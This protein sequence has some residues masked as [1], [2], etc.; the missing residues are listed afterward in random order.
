MDLKYA[1]LVSFLN[2]SV[3]D[4]LSLQCTFWRSAPKPQTI[5][6]VPCVSVKVPQI[7]KIWRASSGDGISLAG[8]LLDLSAITASVAYSFV[9]GYPFR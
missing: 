8:V 3:I 2:E 4:V 7:L 1:K 5:C 6:P 9:L